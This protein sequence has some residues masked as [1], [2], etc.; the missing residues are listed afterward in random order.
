MNGQPTTANGT[1]ERLLRAAWT[2]VQY[3]GVAG[4][5]SRAITEAAR[6]NLGAITYHFGSKDDLVAEA[7]LASIRTAIQPALTALGREDLD[8]PARVLAALDALRQGFAASADHAPAY[9]EALAQARHLPALA[10]GVQ[11]LFAELRRFL[12]DQIAAEQAGGALGAWI[13]PE[14]MATLILASANG[15]VLHAA[16]DPEATDVA[17]VAGQ[18]V[19]LLLAARVDRVNPPR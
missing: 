12:A 7:L 8:P 17:R 5:T 16:L 15:L 1:R 3:R 13:D 14:S 11:A 18:F 2:C 9:V 6:V 19:G 4:A 10:A